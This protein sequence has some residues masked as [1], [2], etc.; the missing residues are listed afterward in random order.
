MNDYDGSENAPED[1]GFVSDEND[2][3]ERIVNES[4]LDGDSDMMLGMT[5]RSES[6]IDDDEEIEGLSK[7]KAINSSYINLKRNNTLTSYIKRW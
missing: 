7:C 2:M 3:Q 6:A 1:S 4:S 5:G